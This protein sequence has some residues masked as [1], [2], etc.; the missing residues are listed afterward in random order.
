MNSSKVSLKRKIAQMFIVATPP[1]KNQ[2]KIFK[3]IESYVDLGIGGLML[4][5]GGRFKFVQKQGVADIKKLQKFVFKLK[6]LDQSLFLAID[7][8]GGYDFNLFENA[9]PLKPSREYGLR[10]EKDGS[11]K[12]FERDVKNY[13][14]IIS[15]CGVNMNFA[16]VIDVAQKGYNGYISISGRSYS[17]KLKVVNV[18]SSIFI[19]EMQKNNIV[20]VGKHFPG[21]G[22]LDENPHFHLRI[23][24]NIADFEN[25]NLTKSTFS[26]AI[27][28]DKVIG[29]MKGHVLSALDSKF[30]ATLSL[31]IENYL[32]K[33]LNFNGLSITD[34]LFMMALSE[35]Y[36]KRDKDGI[37]R[38]VDAAKCNDIL[39]ISYPKEQD[40]NGRLKKV[41]RKHDHFQRLLNAVYDAVLKGQ[42]PEEKINESYEKI[43]KYKKLLKLV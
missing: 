43:I 8:E 30:P 1:I 29:I 38:I 37:K 32:R 5:I 27:K 34:E 22:P 40:T 16:P 39:L 41:V 25:N 11:T 28:K 14:K 3:I 19:K 26:N 2:K 31:D 6:K 4:G 7:G 9:V 18:L 35:H 24:K 42:I 21:Y 20:A 13:F 36:S 23:Q 10:F 17:D 15:W 33:N 12:E